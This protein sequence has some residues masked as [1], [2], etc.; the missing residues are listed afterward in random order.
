VVHVEGLDGTSDLLVHRKVE[1]G[2]RAV[3]RCP[4]PAVLALEAGVSRLRYPR[5]RD[6]F[7]AQRA[8][9]ERWDCR[10]LGLR[11]E[12]VGEAG[13]CVLVLEVGPPKPDMRGLFV[14]ESSLSG[15]E[16]WEAVISGGLAGR[17]E[18]AAGDAAGRVDGPPDTLAERLLSFLE[19]K[20]FA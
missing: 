19:E 6:R 18:A 14:P 12:E 3:I 11:P 9:I 16:R 7:R 2:Y 8:R 1:R 17:A 20:G 10:R 13:S 15:M 5:L 4:L